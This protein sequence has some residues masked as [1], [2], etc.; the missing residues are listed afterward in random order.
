MRWSGHKSFATPASTLERHVRGHEK[1]EG[2]TIDH[3][4]PARLLFGLEG[5]DRARF[6]QDAA[7][8][9]ESW[10]R[11]AHEQPPHELVVGERKRVLVLVDCNS[12]VF[13]ERDLTGLVQSG[14]ELRYC[15]A[16]DVDTSNPDHSDSSSALRPGGMSASG[17]LPEQRS[18]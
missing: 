12:D 14:R 3:R 1:H 11:I 2:A 9:L 18:S 6:V 10:D 16:R 7:Q 4:D 15:G 17:F 13:G 5:V 8:L